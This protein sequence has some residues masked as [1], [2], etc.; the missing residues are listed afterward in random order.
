MLWQHQEA[1]VANAVSWYLASSTAGYCLGKQ[2]L[3][4][5]SVQTVA[6]Q[7]VEDQDGTKWELHE[8]E[9]CTLPLPDNRA[10]TSCM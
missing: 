7:V 10:C 1:G 6:R 5:M 4:L 3:R 8:C 2:H 9:R